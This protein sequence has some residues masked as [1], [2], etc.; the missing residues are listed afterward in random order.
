MASL[1]ASLGDKVQSISDNSGSADEQDNLREIR[2]LMS[3]LNEQVK[4][5][6]DTLTSL[7]E[8]V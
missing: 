8:E 2:D 1:I 5:V 4:T 3:Q 6:S 7:S